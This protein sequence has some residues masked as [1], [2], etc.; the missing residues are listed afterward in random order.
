M[1]THRLLPTTPIDITVLPGLRAALWDRHDTVICAG[2][3]LR[4]YEERWDYIDPAQ[5]DSQEAAL[6]D[7]LVRQVGNG[8]FLD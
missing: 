2:E 4:L 8:V 1:Q 7:Q 3:L 5:I 6:L